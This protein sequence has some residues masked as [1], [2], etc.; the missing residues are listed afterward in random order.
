[1]ELT[2]GCLELGTGLAFNLSK[3]SPSLPRFPMGLDIVDSFNDVDLSDTNVSV[4]DGGSSMER[5]TQLCIIGLMNTSESCFTIVE[6]LVL[7]AITH[8]GS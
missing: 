1:M 7:W 5:G 2:L 6:G 3:E 8:E 4:S